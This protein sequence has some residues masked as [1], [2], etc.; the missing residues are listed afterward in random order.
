M[1]KSKCLLFL[2]CTSIN[3]CEYLCAP[4]SKV[5]FLLCLFIKMVAFPLVS[6]SKCLLLSLCAYIFMFAFSRVHLYQKVCFSSCVST[7]KCFLLLMSANIKTVAFSLLCAYIK[8]FANFRLHLNQ[9]VFFYSCASHIKMIA[10]SCL[11]LLVC[12]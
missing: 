7:S 12:A 11:L 1:S 2:V 9:N 5:C 10:N 4:T 6:S 8:M 3:F